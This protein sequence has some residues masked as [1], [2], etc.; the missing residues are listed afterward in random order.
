MSFKPDDISALGGTSPGGG[1]EENAESIDSLEGKALKVLTPA[2]LAK[3]IALNLDFSA[4]RL[5]LENDFPGYKLPNE[6]DLVALKLQGPD[7]KI[8]NLKAVTGSV[9]SMGSPS[10]DL[11]FFDEKGEV[12]R[13]RYLNDSTFSSIS[14]DNKED[15]EWP[16]LRP[17]DCLFLIKKTNS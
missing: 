4:L 13:S 14:I 11:I 10:L 5:Q 1:T 2:Y 6:A 16:H 17:G 7:K 15:K 9:G 3:I 8:E 12:N